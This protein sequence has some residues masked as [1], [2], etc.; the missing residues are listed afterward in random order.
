MGR[1]IQQLKKNSDNKEP[2]QIVN[3]INSIKIDMAKLESD[4]YKRMLKTIPPEKVLK[5]IKAE[6]EVYRSMV[7]RRSDEQNRRH[8]KGQGKWAWQKRPHGADRNAVRG[9]R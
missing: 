4:Y 7:Q 9:E 1:Q 5:V 3:K 8:E 2:A 6:D